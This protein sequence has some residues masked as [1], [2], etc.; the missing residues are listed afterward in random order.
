[1]MRVQQVM[2]PIGG[3]ASARPLQAGM[4]PLQSTTIPAQGNGL[5]ITSLMNMMIM[6]MIVVTVRGKT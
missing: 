5:D 6:M 1:M 3:L 4:V 2:S